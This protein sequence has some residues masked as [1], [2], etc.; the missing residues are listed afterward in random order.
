M[1]SLTLATFGRP[2]SLFALS[3]ATRAHSITG[4]IIY[5]QKL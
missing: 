2:N 3:S 1:L 4:G 5:K